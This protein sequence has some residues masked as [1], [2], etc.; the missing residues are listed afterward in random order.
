MST[1]IT[2]RGSFSAFQPP[3]RGTVHASISYHGP[4]KDWVYDQVARDLEVVK[5]SI[6]RLED[7]DDGAVTRWSA[8]QLRTWSHRPRNEDGDELPVIHDAS[9]SVE[10]RFRDF[11]ALSQWVGGHVTGTEGFEL[12][13]VE[14]ALTTKSRDELVTRV[15][16]QAVQDAAARAQLYADALELGKVRPIA[17]ADAGMLGAEAHSQGG[18]GMGFLHAAPASS[19]GGPDVELVPKDISVSATVDAR[20]VA[21]PS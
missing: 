19:G 8:A 13:Y 17:I 14:W 9:V 12:R 21:A 5:E 4:E 20:F 16:T 6:L 18:D 1:E 15:R 2:V 10:V 7:G 3:E 11:T